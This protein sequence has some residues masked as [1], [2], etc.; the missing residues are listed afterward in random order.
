MTTEINIDYYN[1]L[2]AKADKWDEL[3]NMSDEEYI[4][5]CA[6]KKGD[7]CLYN[8]TEKAYCP[9]KKLISIAMIGGTYGGSKYWL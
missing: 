1:E 8:K 5:T 4:E 2:K 6:F 7:D 9:C 3:N